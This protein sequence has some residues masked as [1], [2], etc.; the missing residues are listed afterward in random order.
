MTTLFSRSQQIIFIL[1]GVSI[2]TSIAITNFLL[3]LIA[4]CWIYE[5][6]FKVKF[7]KIFFSVWPILI[8]VLLLL[9]FIGMF[10]G[11]YHDN[12]SWQFQKLA[13]LLF[14]PIL[15]TLSL[16]R[17]TMQYALTA[18]LITNFISALI[19]ILIN[20]Q[21]IKPLSSYF[22]FIESFYGT[23]AFIKYNYH[24]VLLAF[25]SIICLYLFLEKK[26]KYKYL[27]IFFFIVYALSIFTERGRAGQLLFNLAMLFYILRYAAQRNVGL[28]LLMFRFLIF[29]TLLFSF[30]LFMY[31]KNNSYKKRVDA[32]SE[33]IQNNGQRKGYKRDIRYVFIEE[34][35]KD[36]IKKPIL[37]YGTGSFGKIFIIKQKK[38]IISSEYKFFDWITPHN[39]YLYVWFE[40]GFLGLLCLILIFYLQAKKLLKQCDGLFKVCLPVSFML[41]MMVDSYLFI[42]I[43]TSAYIFL[44]TICSRYHLEPNEISE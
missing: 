38:G 21:I 2:P 23:S 34:T 20:Y 36:I 39:Q 30:N 3:I 17:R 18:F 42:F 28:K 32:V 43:L 7:K 11:T 13:L 6:N 27:V 15:M 31:N 12:S 35:L 40:I 33:I 22:T 16:T 19:A 41:L 5:R 1:L 26:T 10:W 29:C 24:N 37:G 14:F 25:S 9:Y 4:L 44:Y 8:I